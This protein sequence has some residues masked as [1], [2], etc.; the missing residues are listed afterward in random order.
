ML[1]EV[2]R[3]LGPTLTLDATLA[4]VLKA[5]RTLV[6]FRGG[7]IALVEDAALRVMVSDPPVS[8][9]V[10]D[11]R[12]PVGSGIAGRAVALGTTMYVPDLDDDPRVDA[13]IRRAGSNAGMTSFLAV[14]LVCL[15]RPIGILQVDS[16]ER[17]AFDDVDQMLL[18]GLATQTANAIESARQYEERA[19]LD[20]LKHGFINLVSHE[21]RT[22]L[23]IAS[24]M[25]ETHRN[26]AAAAASGEELDDLLDR[27]GNALTRLGRLIEELITMSELAAG[28]ITPRHD[29]IVLK[30]LLDRVAVAAPEPSVVSVECPDGLVLS[31]DPDLLARVLAA[32]VENA[33]V[34]AGDAALVADE[35]WIEVRDHGPGI[36]E[37]IVD[38]ETEIFSRSVRND[39][40]VAGLGL[41]LGMATALVS[42]LGGTLSIR[43]SPGS[44][45][46]V[47]LTFRR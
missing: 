17:D 30:E 10:R 39:T 5:M 6:D 24:G 40:T 21:L 42:E 29:R 35:G 14:P 27:A 36:P 9:E 22:P 37:D 1:T 23:M 44:G 43:S 7:S 4:A 2:S 8:A 34:Y 20:G 32:L 46:A 41:G 15:G 18:E 11:L 19:R 28:T 26:L 25:L 3:G 45:S 16:A 12:L 47:R 31:T 38:R 33:V 13:D